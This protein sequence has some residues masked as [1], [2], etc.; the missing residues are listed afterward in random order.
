MKTLKSADQVD[1]GNKLLKSNAL[2]NPDILTI[3]TIL[4]IELDYRSDEIVSQ[5]L[6]DDL[7]GYLEPRN[8]EYV[9]EQ[10]ISSGEMWYFKVTLTGT[11]GTQNIRYYCYVECEENPRQ[12]DKYW[13]YYLLN[14]AP[15]AKD[16]KILIS[17]QNIEDPHVYGDVMLLAELYA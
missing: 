1:I 13:I 7:L 12:D 14:M 17:Y 6:S 15:A 16:A 2:V 11:N 4:G 10:E 5:E 9:G 8:K 3:A